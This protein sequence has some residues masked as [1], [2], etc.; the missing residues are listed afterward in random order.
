MARKFED[1]IGRFVMQDT[2]GENSPMSKLTKL[3]AMHIRKCAW[4][5]VPGRE[6]AALFGVT[7]PVVSNIKHCRSWSDN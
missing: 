7:P 2:K 5:G 4:A 1:N 3:E 6:L